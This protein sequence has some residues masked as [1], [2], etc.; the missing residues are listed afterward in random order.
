MTDTTPASGPASGGF[1]SWPTGRLLS[2]AARLVERTWEEQL[3]THGMTHAGLI[4]LHTLADGPHSQRDMARACQVTDQ[5]MSRTV[6]R[7]E[8]EGF[9]SRET[10]PRDERRLRVR[11]TDT[12]HE[13]YRR[14]LALERDDTSL[15]AGVSDPGAL[16]RLLLELIRSRQVHRDRTESEGGPGNRA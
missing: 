10:D 15:T 13:I 3:R 6:E 8:R 14:L 5:T 12:G 2:T 4:A 16:R 11:I 9:V 1:D 7:L